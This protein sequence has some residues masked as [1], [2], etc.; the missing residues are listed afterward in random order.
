MKRLIIA[1]TFLLTC[2]FFDSFS[3]SC[4]PPQSGVFTASVI[5]IINNAGCPGYVFVQLNTTNGN[6]YISP[7]D[8][9]YETEIA[10]VITAKAKGTQIEVN[11]LNNSNGEKC[12]GSTCYGQISWLTMK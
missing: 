9:N 1:S 4:T 7:T 12:G 3:Q 6:F 10:C 8:P 11:I 2:M 5:V